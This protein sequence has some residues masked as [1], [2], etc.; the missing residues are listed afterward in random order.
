MVEFGASESE[1]SRWETLDWPF[2]AGLLRV[3]K[4]YS[5]GPWIQSIYFVAPKEN[6]VSQAIA[7]EICEEGRHHL[8]I[9]ATHLLGQI[10][11]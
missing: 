8:V 11:D 5:C 2:S 1:W 7:V 9:S 10:F 3:A 4:S 6:W